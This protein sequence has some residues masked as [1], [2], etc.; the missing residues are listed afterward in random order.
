MTVIFLL[1]TRL[2]N[3]EVRPPARRYTTIEIQAGTHVFSRPPDD[4]R[5]AL[6][7]HP[8]RSCSD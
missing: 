4:P 6:P 1:W 5:E 8:P 2:V 3:Q 7:P